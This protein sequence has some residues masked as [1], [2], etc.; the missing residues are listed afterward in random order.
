MSECLNSLKSKKPVLIKRPTFEINGSELGKFMLS[1]VGRIN[2]S[3]WNLIVA[4]PLYQLFGFWIGTSKK[5]AERMVCSAWCGYVYNNFY[6]EKF[7]HWSRL[8]PEDLFNDNV[9]FKSIYL[10]ENDEIKSV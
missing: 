3:K 2:Y 6:P 5:N 7:K 4:Q 1:K 9:D 8:D 10:I